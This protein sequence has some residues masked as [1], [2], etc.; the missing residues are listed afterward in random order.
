MAIGQNADSIGSVY[1]Q[2]TG[3]LTILI[4]TG[5]PSVPRRLGNAQVHLPHVRMTIVRRLGNPSAVGLKP[6]SGFLNAAL[7]PVTAIRPLW[8]MSSLTLAEEV[9]K[10]YI[11]RKVY[12]V[13]PSGKSRKCLARRRYSQRDLR[14]RM[15]RLER[16]VWFHQ[17]GI[18]GN[19]VSGGFNS[20]NLDW[21][22]LGGFSNERI[23][24]LEL[25]TEE[26]AGIDQLLN[27]DESLSGQGPYSI[28]KKIRVC[29]GSP[30]IAEFP[31]PGFC[32][33]HGEKT[34]RS[35]FLGVNKNSGT[36]RV[37]P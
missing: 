3:T 6:K 17:W 9:S 34:D 19:V 11:L 10:N 1:G 15:T 7:S 22:R 33:N 31:H 29:F 18:E 2:L 26:T 28:G 20:S 30:D 36:S 35:Q 32:S 23:R 27:S 5:E 12:H 13:N 25:N 8:V 14:K 24:T 37:E 21:E 4:G 16:P